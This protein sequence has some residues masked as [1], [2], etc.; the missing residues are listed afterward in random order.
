[1]AALIKLTETLAR[2]DGAT[3]QQ[4][5]YMAVDVLEYD[6]LDVLVTAS[7]QAPSGGPSFAL[8]L[9]SGMQMVTTD[10]WIKVGSTSPTMSPTSPTV[11]WTL[12][13]GFFRYVRWSVA[14]FSSAAP[15]RFT[16]DLV[17]RRNS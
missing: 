15:I 9:I 3:D 6:A 7:F 11:A 5:L 2:V 10:S 8:N 16:I 17:G 13:G 4:A 1:V 12:N 14:A